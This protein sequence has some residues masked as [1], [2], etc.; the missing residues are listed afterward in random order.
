MAGDTA[1]GGVKGRASAFGSDGRDG[2]PDDGLCGFAEGCDLVRGVL[3][4]KTGSKGSPDEAEVGAEAGLTHVIEVEAGFGRLDEDLVERFHFMGGDG[5]EQALFIAEGEGGGAG[6][7]G[8]IGHVQGLEVGELGTGS[9]QTHV[10]AQ[11][12]PELRQFVELIAAKEGAGP[13]D[14]LVAADGDAGALAAFDAHGAEFVEGKL[15]A[16]AAHAALAE[17]DRALRIEKNKGG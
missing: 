4:R 17:E 10:A 6:E 9:H 15:A 7:A 14:A 1:P 16:V 13:G 2:R 11:D 8:A 12:V 5:G 3:G